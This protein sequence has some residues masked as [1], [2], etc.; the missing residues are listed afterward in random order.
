MDPILIGLG[1]RIVEKLLPY[2]S[3]GAEKLTQAVGETAVKKLE[4]LLQTLKTR[5]GGDKEVIDNITRFEKKPEIYRAAL[6][7]I[8]Q[9][10]LE[11]DKN[12]AA[13]LD[14][15][16]KDI[17][18]ITIKQRIGEAHKSVT[19]VKA[20]GIRRGNLDIDQDI[21]KAHETVTGAEFDEDIG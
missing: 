7:D 8:L 2:V 12:I 16:L 9:E 13:E 4:K 18:V 10:K 17:P 15:Q 11:G 21:E 1:T 3:E 19:A 6:E 5:F 20:K 14:R